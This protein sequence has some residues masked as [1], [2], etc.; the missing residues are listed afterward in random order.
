MDIKKQ[1]KKNCSRL[2][3]KHTL[4]K[5]IFTADEICCTTMAKQWHMS[6]KHA[7]K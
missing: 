4:V 2:L 3:N 6:Q 1:I 5:Y 7:Y